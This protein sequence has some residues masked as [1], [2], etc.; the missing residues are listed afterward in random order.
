[1]TTAVTGSRIKTIKTKLLAH[2]EEMQAMNSEKQQKYNGLVVCVYFTASPTKT[3]RGKLMNITSRI[4]ND[5]GDHYKEEIENNVDIQ[6]YSHD[7]YEWKD[8][9]FRHTCEL[10]KI[11]KRSKLLSVLRKHIDESIKWKVISK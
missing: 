10:Q 8:S 5:L 9:R 2:S 4:A 6:I 7:K 1:V 3:V 11:E